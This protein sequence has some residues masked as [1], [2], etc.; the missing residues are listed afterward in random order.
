ML[1]YISIV[2]LLLICL[3][4]EAITWRGKLI[5]AD[6]K[7]PLQGAT[8]T[9][10]I[11]GKVVFTNAEGLFDIEGNVGDQVK[12]YCPAYR[13]QYHVIISGLKDIRL[14]FPMKLMGQD[15]QEVT[16]TQKYKTQYQRDS[17]SRYEE[18]SRVLARE[19]TTSI[20]SPFSLLAERLSKKQRAIFKFKKDF[21]KMEQSQYTDS[22]YNPE[23]VAV[24][25]NFSGD[26][27]AYFMNQYPMPYDYSRNATALELKMWIRYN[28]KDFLS[29]T[30]SLRTLVL[31]Y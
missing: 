22:R 24:L 15:L 28:Y 3:P 6:N 14:T 25:T 16:I 19:K 13:V 2:F 20:M 12:F 29:K 17:A 4:S 21:Y 26:T 27:L 23:L 11:N 8:I 9:N 18:S 30:D 10:T 5:D 7:N 1:R 31:P